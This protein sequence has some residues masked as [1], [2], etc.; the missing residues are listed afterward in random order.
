MWYGQIT[1]IRVNFLVKYW[2]ISAA[3][4]SSF[5]WHL[6]SPK[7]H[8][9]F[10][11]YRVIKAPTFHWHCKQLGWTNLTPNCFE[12]W[13]LIR[14]FNWNLTNN[15]KYRLSK[16]FSLNV[17]ILSSGMLLNKS[18]Q[19]IV[20]PL[21]IFGRLQVRKQFVPIGCEMGEA[22]R[23]ARTSSQHSV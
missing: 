11:F 5:L 19:K 17:R 14:K 3:F 21:K 1:F 13:L 9:Q 22:T 18:G 12:V 10:F 23:Y 16:P 15:G 20:N 7:S 6:R 8:F 4:W 2:H